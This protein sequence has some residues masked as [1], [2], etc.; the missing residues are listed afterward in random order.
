MRS[1]RVII[2]TVI[3]VFTMI[4]GH[5]PAN[6]SYADRH[7]LS[8]VAT[9]APDDPDAWQITPLDPIPPISH[10]WLVSRRLFIHGN[11]TPESDFEDGN[12]IPQGVSV[13][14]LARF[15]I[16]A[17]ENFHVSA[18]D[19]HSLAVSE[20][21]VVDPAITDPYNTPVIKGG[22]KV[23]FKGW[24]SWASH[25][26]DPSSDGLVLTDPNGTTWAFGNSLNGDFPGIEKDDAWFGG[27]ESYERW[28]SFGLDC[29][30]GAFHLEGLR[31]VCELRIGVERA[32]D[33][34]AGNL[35]LHKV[36][37]NSSD[38]VFV[39]FDYEGDGL[40]LFETTSDG[41]FAEPDL[42]LPTSIDK[43]RYHFRAS[44]LQRFFRMTARK[45]VYQCANCHNEDGSITEPDDE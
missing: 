29:K 30:T 18:G 27:T 7:L 9:L 37:M 41:D 36:G 5:L 26:F 32:S 23:S 6:P 25:D 20:L 19:N 3:I 11:S 15:E 45:T 31:L 38:T 35:R 40:L 39:E 10:R 22:F 14:F 1:Q 12:R 43:N 16:R 24:N 13:S 2:S 42:I 44:D 28:R 34:D 17:A 33:T 4:A 8:F 21:L